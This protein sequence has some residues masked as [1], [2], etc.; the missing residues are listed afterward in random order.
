MVVLIMYDK[1]T[2]NDEPYI[3]SNGEIICDEYLPEGN[4]MN[5]ESPFGLF[6]YLII[7]GGF[8]DIEEMTS[9]FLNDLD[10]TSCSPRMLDKLHGVNLGLPRPKILDDEE[11]R[12]LTDDEYRVYLYI[13]D[14]QL[15]TKL[16]L[17]S[18]FGHCMGNDE[19]D[20]PYGGVT[21]TDE[22]NNQFMAVDH[23]HYNSPVTDESDI[24]VNTDDDYNR[25]TNKLVDDE[26]V[27]RISGRTS[28]SGDT[29]TY[30]NVPMK[31]WS[32]VF[33]DFLTDFISIKGNVLVR[34]VIV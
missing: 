33:L 6:L 11:L 10:I 34:E 16:D 30:V 23:L 4:P 28:Y 22:P 2:I 19:L 20:D 13:R 27:Y 7:G 32:P 17:L 25:F 26:D 5:P 15:L 14:S 3:S 31:G 21:I 1:L 29:I 18:V 9:N 24:G 8:D 12:L